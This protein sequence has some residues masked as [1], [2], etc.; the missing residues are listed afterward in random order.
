MVPVPDDDKGATIEVSGT[1]K[2]KL[3]DNKVA[4]DLTAGPAGRRC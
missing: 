3:G 1:V 2:E 4:V